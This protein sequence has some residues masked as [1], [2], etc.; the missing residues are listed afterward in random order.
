[1]GLS[2]SKKNNLLLKEETI[3]NNH[4][5]FALIYNCDLDG[6]KKTLSKSDTFNTEWIR[7]AIEH[8]QWAVIEFFLLNDYYDIEDLLD[9]ELFT[10]NLL[11]LEIHVKN[12]PLNRVNIRNASPLKA[13]IE[14]NFEFFY[15]KLE[16]LIEVALQTSKTQVIEFLSTIQV[17]DNKLPILNMDLVFFVCV[18]NMSHR[19]RN[20]LQSDI[21]EFYLNNQGI[22]FPMSALLD[23]APNLLFE[24]FY[25]GDDTK[26]RRQFCEL[27]SRDV[28]PLSL[29]MI[30]LLHDDDI[31]LEEFVRDIKTYYL[32]HDYLFKMCKVM[33]AYKHLDEILVE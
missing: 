11:D 9:S 23:K 3:D 1:M 15:P 29:L 12:K 33:N 2:I 24:H 19:R 13:I 17:P 7:F 14:I 28:V 26:Y 16:P 8:N 30:G 22:D 31:H 20:E 21:V 6:I 10:F 25:K 4:P 18:D 32:D 5:I 27:M